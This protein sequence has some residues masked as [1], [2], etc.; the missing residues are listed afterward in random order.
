M[1]ADLRELAER[2]LESKLAERERAVLARYDKDKK[3]AILFL[4]LFVLFFAAGA[5][6]FAWRGEMGGVDVTVWSYYVGGFLLGVSALCLFFMIACWR[7]FAADKKE[8]AEIR[9]L[10]APYS[11]NSR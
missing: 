4:V 11:S 7:L 5:F 2:L 3:E 6:L 9:K 10:Q 8:L 1:A